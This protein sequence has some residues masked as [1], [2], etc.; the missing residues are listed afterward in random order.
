MKNESCHIDIKLPKIFCSKLLP[1]L[2][3]AM[4]QLLATRG[5][6]LVDYANKLHV[7]PAL[8]AAPDEICEWLTDQVRNSEIL[9]KVLS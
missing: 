4:T 9:F 7:A 5:D 6:S 8:L 2:K 1:S 3:G